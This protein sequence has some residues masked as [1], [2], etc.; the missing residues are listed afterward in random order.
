[1]EGV[2]NYVVVSNNGQRMGAH[3]MLDAISKAKQFVS[4]WKQV[5]SKDIEAKVYYRDGSHVVTVDCSN[6]DDKA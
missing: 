4:D 1:M 6:C 2:M 5:G 3:T